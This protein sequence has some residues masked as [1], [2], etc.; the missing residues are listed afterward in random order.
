MSEPKNRDAA[1]E[2]MA[3]P[4]SPYSTRERM[5]ETF[6]MEDNRERK[7]RARHNVETKQA[8]HI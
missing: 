8:V 1:R 4:K 2:R 5:A 7:R 6:A 3:E